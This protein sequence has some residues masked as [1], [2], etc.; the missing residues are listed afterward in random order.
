MTSVKRVGD[1]CIE[2][3]QGD[4]VDQRVDAI[5][6][7][8]NSAL[9]GGG[10]VDGAIHRAAGPSLLEECRALPVDD[11][12][13]RCGT[14]DARI[15]GAGALAAKHVIHGVGPVYDPTDPDGSARLLRSVHLAAL[16]LARDA[17]CES[18]AFP[19]IST[20]VYRFPVPEAAGVALSTTAGFLAGPEAGSVSL[21]RFVLFSDFDRE[22]FARA[23]SELA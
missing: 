16:R 21:V 12:G 20:G 18:V 13:L 4:I 19:A 15:T 3:V 11:R 2:L 6:N 14:G 9:L 23:L 5:V 1:R 8:A 10:G 17:A 7:A 22:A